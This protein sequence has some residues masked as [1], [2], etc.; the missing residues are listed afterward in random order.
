MIFIG[1]PDEIVHFPSNTFGI[2]AN[3]T[4]EYA[5]LVVFSDFSLP[6]RPI[7]CNATQGFGECLDGR[8]YPIRGRCNHYIDCE[9]GSD[10]A[11]C[12][13]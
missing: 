11:G 12:K 9:D 8:C 2:D 10:E 4:F 5:G 13:Y 3:R 6:Q 7:F 1:Y